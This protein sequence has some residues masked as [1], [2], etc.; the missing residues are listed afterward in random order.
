MKSVEE[1]LQT[2]RIVKLQYS[3]RYIRTS[4][5]AAVLVEIHKVI[6]TYSPDVVLDIITLPTQCKQE[7]DF[8]FMSDLE[9]D[10]YINKLWK[11]HSLV[12]NLEVNST[13]QHERFFTI[14]FSNGEKVTV[15]LDNG[16]SY[17][18]YIDKNARFIRIPEDPCAKMSTE[19]TIR[20]KYPS[21]PV[22]VV[23]E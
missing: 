15:L 1:L 12:V 17:W 22:F 20:A 23:I 3:D 11:I 21:M 7:S 14:V 10:T 5:V 19:T 8:E 18:C 16:V 4:M 6:N 2:Q 13:P 9:R